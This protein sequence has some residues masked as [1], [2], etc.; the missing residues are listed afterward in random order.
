[1]QKVLCFRHANATF[2]CRTKAHTHTHIDTAQLVY[3]HTHTP[4]CIFD[5]DSCSTWARSSDW[6]RVATFTI[7]IIEQILMCAS[8]HIRAHSYMCAF[9]IRFAAWSLK[10]PTRTPT[11]ILSNSFLFTKFICSHIVRTQLHHHTQTHRHTVY[12]INIKR[13]CQSML[14]VCVCSCL[15][16]EWFIYAT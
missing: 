5:F 3:T 9:F 11:L 13:Y 16:M 2:I 6:N 10:K 8:T 15:W 14:F 12:K 4:V 7:L 1:M